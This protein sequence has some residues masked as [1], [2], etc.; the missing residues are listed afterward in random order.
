M[1]S[2]L[3]P[4]SAI[5]GADQIDAG[6]VYSTSLSQTHEDIRAWESLRGIDQAK[7]NLFEVSPD[8]SFAD[9]S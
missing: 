7:D 6:A 4:S 8:I 3:D 9:P 2:C 5:M 1:N